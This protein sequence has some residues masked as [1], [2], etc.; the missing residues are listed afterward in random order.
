KVEAE[1]TMELRP[2]QGGTV[3]WVS[4]SSRNG[5]TAVAGEV[6]LRLDP[7]P[8][9]DALAL[10]RADLTEARANAAD[11]IAAVELASEDLVAAQTQADLRQQALERQK[12]IAARGAGSD[13]AVETTE[14]ALSAA[15]QAVLSRKQ[16]LAAA[17]ARVAQTAVAVTRA[18]LGLG[19]AERALAETR[20]LAGFSGRI[21]GVS[22]VT[23][24][25]VTAN[26]SL[27]RIIDPASMVVALRLSTA[28]Y[29]RL[30]DDG[31]ALQASSV[32]VTLPGLPD[33]LPLRGR[34]D[35]A[36]AAVG[37]GQS[38]RLIYVALDAGPGGLAL[39]KPGDFVE[40]SIQGETLPDAALVPATAVGRQ[41]TVL[42]LGPDD[43]LQ[44]VSATVLGRQGDDVIIAVGA[45]AGR[46]IV[47]ERSAVLGDG[48]RV[49]P[50]RPG[51]PLDE[52]DAAVTKPTGG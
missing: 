46:E 40:V 4:D 43:R 7:V 44:E 9:E 47:V 13:Q 1:R 35:R 3:A 21:D 16:A 36:G 26:E 23:G 12:D 14:L 24:A 48:I 38:G 45:L 39:L 25:I 22:V 11:A 37:E 15:T 49:R 19:D 34:L 33:A 18:E 6:L 17:R 52:A 28:Q 29:A 30:V 51:Q 10:A 8:A 2:R 50:I 20:L 5:G 32:A 31:G 41:G 27:G 42:V